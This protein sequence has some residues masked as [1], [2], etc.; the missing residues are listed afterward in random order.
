M[1]KRQ[2]M[3]DHKFAEAS[4]G[5]SVRCRGRARVASPSEFVT[6]NP[7]FIYSTVFGHERGL[8]LVCHLGGNTD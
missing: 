5:F 2:I 7:C 6:A 4:F 8:L 3:F 1:L